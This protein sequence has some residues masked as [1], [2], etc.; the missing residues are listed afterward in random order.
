MRKNLLFLVFFCFCS[1]TLSQEAPQETSSSKS[2][3]RVN[4]KFNTLEGMMLEFG[5]DKFGVALGQT[6]GSS[7]GSDSNGPYTFS[8]TFTSLRGAYYL[9]GFASDGWSVSGFVGPVTAR[10]NQTISGTPYTANGSGTIIGGAGGY[11][12]FWGGFNLGAGLGLVSVSVATIK[13]TDASGTQVSTVNS[14]TSVGVGMDLTL[15]YA[16]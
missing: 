12:W 3:K 6:S 13:I 10:V 15:G 4:I 7:S 11:N 16:F 5:F 14:P 8:T 9:N 1:T 2:S